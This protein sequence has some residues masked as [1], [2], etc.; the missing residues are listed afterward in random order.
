MGIADGEA[1]HQHQGQKDPDYLSPVIVLPHRV[2]PSGPVCPNRL[3]PGRNLRGSCRV[4]QI[5]VR[6]SIRR[7]KHPCRILR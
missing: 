1:K 6:P 4:V 3:V 5:G 7:V 2:K